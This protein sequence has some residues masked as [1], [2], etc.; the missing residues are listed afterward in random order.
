MFTQAAS[1][2][3]DDFLLAA[4]SFLRRAELEEARALHVSHARIPV[5]FALPLCANVGYRLIRFSCG[6]LFGICL[7]PKRSLSARPA[8]TLKT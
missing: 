8:I 1:V 2:A 3:E 4:K 7:Q 5:R 6:M